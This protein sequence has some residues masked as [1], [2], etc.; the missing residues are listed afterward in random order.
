MRRALQRRDKYCQF[1]GC[2][3]TR[4]VDAHHIHHWADGG[5]TDIGNLVLLCRTHHR[6][7][8]EGGFQLSRLPGGAFH[9]INLQGEVVP[10]VP[11][12]RSRGNAFVLESENSKSGLQIDHKTGIPNWL[13]GGME[14]DIVI[15]G[16]LRRQES[17]DS[18]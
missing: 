11:K 8:H 2:T 12:K 16:L 9:F 6:L 10:E 4:F 5:E 17:K 14:M 1:P 3:C 15:E 13:G 7:V 18:E